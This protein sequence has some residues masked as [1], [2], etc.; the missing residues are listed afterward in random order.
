MFD[1]TQVKQLLQ[2]AEQAWYACL[3]QTSLIRGCPNEQNIAHQTRVQNKCF[4]LLLKLM[5]DGQILSNTTKHNQTHTNTIKQHQTRCPETVTN[6][7]SPN[8]V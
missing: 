4:K 2:A 6:V 7:W 1:Q 8:N 5:F 3:L